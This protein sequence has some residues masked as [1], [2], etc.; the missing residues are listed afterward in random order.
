MK[1]QQVIDWQ[2]EG[3]SPI[4]AEGELWIAEHR[5]ISET[6]RMI[7]RYWLPQECNTGCILPRGIKTE[8]FAVLYRHVGRDIGVAS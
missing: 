3:S 4:E 1:N 6:F 5:G 2:G 7:R 8:K